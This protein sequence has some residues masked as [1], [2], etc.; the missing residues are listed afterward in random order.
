MTEPAGTRPLLLEVD[1]QSW[2]RRL[3]RVDPW[4][5]ATATLQSTYRRLVGQ[6]AGA[7]TEPHVRTYLHDLQERAHVHSGVV[8]ELY[9]AFGRPRRADPPLVAAGSLLLAAGRQVAA[10]VV[11]RVAGTRGEAWRGMR[12]LM[13][14]NLDA[15][16][17]FAV[18][19]Q[20]GLALGI[21]AVI[22]LTVPVLQEKQQH[23]LLLQEYLLEF[24][25]QAVLR[26]GDV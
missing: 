8:E 10:Q 20:L 9:A 24:A 13:R 22:D 4:L 26:D 16:S 2:D 1:P 11:G 6:V 5:A 21:P 3:E 17:G 18:T 14:S 7:V 25:A 19:E 23:Q 12:E 15:I